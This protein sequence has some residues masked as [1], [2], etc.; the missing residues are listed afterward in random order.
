MN[1]IRWDRLILPVAGI[2]LGLFLILRP[3]NAT[4][5]LCSFID[6][7]ILMVGVL[8]VVNALA[9]QRA[10]M[11][12]SPMLPFTVGAIVI[13]LFFIAS[14]GTLAALVGM[15]VCVMLMVAGIGNLQT[16]ALRRGWGD[17]LWWLP[18][19]TGVLCVLLGVYALLFPGASAVFV[20]RMVGVMMLISS[21][22]NL[23]NV[24]T[25]RE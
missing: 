12:A 7:L 10:T 1:N 25:W 17:R 22:V 15:I 4:A 9:F 2:V 13:A 6:W 21:A 20:M 16:A 23:I 18:L 8:G 5:A 14:P 11:L 24:L 19:V 3:W